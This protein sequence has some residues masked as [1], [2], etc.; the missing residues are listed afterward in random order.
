MGGL[1]GL[2][3]AEIAQAIAAT[4]AMKSGP[5]E[6]ALRAAQTTKALRPDKTLT[7]EQ[8]MDLKRTSA[9]KSPEEINYIKAGTK[10]RDAQRV[11]A[12]GRDYKTSQ[13]YSDA[14]AHYDDL[15]RKVQD[16]FGVWKNDM[17]S[18]DKHDKATS[19]IFKDMTYSQATAEIARAIDEDARLIW[20]G[21][22]PNY[23][24]GTLGPARGKGVVNRGASSL[25]Q[26]YNVDR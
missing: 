17:W 3:P 21:K 4:E 26:R 5:G 20:E 14:N 6:R 24:T 25:I 11:T 8:K 13:Q 7:F 15:Y 12:A 23:A 19:G 10:L 1:V 18:L 2:E 9:T 22:P 16:E